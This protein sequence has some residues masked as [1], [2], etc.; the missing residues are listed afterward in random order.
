MKSANVEQRQLTVLGL[1]GVTASPL[2]LSRA[3]RE[4]LQRAPADGTVVRG[5]EESVKF[6][7]SNP[8][9]VTGMTIVG[10]TGTASDVG[11]AWTHGWFAGAIPGRLV[12]VVYVPHGDG[13]MAARLA[14]RFFR[15]AV[16]DRAR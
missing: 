2:E 11:E 16:G 7:M 1:S 12:I 15:A 14:Q 13:G 4:L 10:K 8:A 6:G 9:G 3:Y 5:L